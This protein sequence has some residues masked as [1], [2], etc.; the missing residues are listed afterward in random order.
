MTDFLIE[1]VDA[2]LRVTINHSER[3]NAMT[4]DMAIELTRIIDGA[5]QN[6]RVM[7]LRGA[8]D[9]FCVGRHRGPGAP[10]PM[11][12]A[13]VRREVSDIIFNCYGAFRR[14]AIPI[15]GI[16]RG[17]AA[18]FGCAIAAACDI[19]LAG[20]HAQ[21]QVPEYAHNIMPTMVMS[22]LVDRVPRKAMGYL[23]YSTATVDAQRALAWGL[24]SEVVP[25]AQ[26]DELADQLCRSILKAPLP[27]TIAVKDFLRSAPDMSVP[28]AVDYAR[29]LHATINSAI[30]ARMKRG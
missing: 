28:G 18:G 5:A 25:E 21:F 9:D 7:V 4:D 27:A 11:T 26:L 14:A 29:N 20:E 12:D 22:A 30:E 23:V 8:G 15:I 2:L 17:R 6:A 1:Q 24:A 13:L 3:G 19:T 16:V 10:P